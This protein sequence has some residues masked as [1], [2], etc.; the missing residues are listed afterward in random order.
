MTTAAPVSPSSTSEAAAGPF[1]GIAEGGRAVLAAPA[2]VRVWT[3]L[4]I[5]ML[6][7]MLPFGRGTLAMVADPH[8]GTGARDAGGILAPL[9]ADSGMLHRKRPGV[10][11]F[12]VRAAGERVLNGGSPYGDALYSTP[13]ATPYRYLPATALWLGVP[14][15]ALPAKAALVA[16][17]AFG[18]VQ[19]LANFLLCAGRRPDAIPVLAP[20]W[21]LWCPLIAEWHLGQAS[22]FLATLLLW[23][24]ELLR[25]ERRAWPLPWV[26]AILLKVFPAAFA[27]AF[28]REGRWR[29]VLAAGVA[30]ALLT[31]PAFAWLGRPDAAMQLEG[32]FLGALRQP[33]AGAQG[34]QE[35]INAIEWKARGLSFA[36]QATSGEGAFP[37]LV[38]VSVL[39]WA[40]FAALLLKRAP[41]PRILLVAPFWL[42][43]FVAFRDVWE[44]HYVMLQ[45]LL[46]L[47]IV[48]TRM[49]RRAVLLAWLGAGAPSLWWLWQRTGYAG[50]A[51]AETVG[52]L[53]FVQRPVALAVIAWWVWRA[54]RDS[55]SG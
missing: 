26:L 46:A 41:T 23:S 16:W 27:F 8:R 47:L 18:F 2:A 54:G 14:L 1:A 24:L 45:P 28:L 39:A 53:Y 42:L 34:V 50:N 52:L 33:Y 10:D 35:F 12:A 30:S 31:F 13:Y 5:A 32:R 20:V 17:V 29:A 9:S 37:A 49:P 7:L 19:V 3:A 43:W 48:E 15:A 38:I 40:V 44:H 21:C 36:T 22:L 11:L 6:A 51:L 4:C 55:A 25:A